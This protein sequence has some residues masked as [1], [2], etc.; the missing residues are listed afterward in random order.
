MT[1]AHSSDQSPNGFALCTEFRTDNTGPPKTTAEV[2]TSLDKLRTEYPG[3]TIKTS[4]FDAFIKDVEPVKAD[5]PVVDLEVG[6]TWMYGSASDP[7]KMAISRGL[8][9]V[10]A[11][12]LESG[13]P[14][15]SYDNPVI[16]NFT[17]FVLK[18][19][20]HT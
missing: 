11:E 7:M 3:A 5:L 17:W 13:E 1:L 9:R 14:A 6:D 16:Q 4:T 2:Q 20:E 15:C 8:Q 10:W 12:C 19:P 18:A